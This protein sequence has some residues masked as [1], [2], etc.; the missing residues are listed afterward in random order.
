MFERFTDRARRVL[1]YAQ[2]EAGSLGHNFLGTEHILLGLVREGE[3][4]GAQ[5]LEALGQTLPEIQGQVLQVLQAFQE[6]G[7]AAGPG[8]RSPALARAL[9]DAARQA[10]DE[11]AVTTSHVIRSVLGVP[12]SQGAMA[13]TRLG[14]TAEAL[15]H[16]VAA[17]PLGQT[18]DS[19]PEARK[20]EIKLGDVTT[21]IADADLA[22]ALR[23]A[24]PEQIRAALQQLVASPVVE[25]SAGGEVQ[26]DDEPGEASSEPPQPEADEG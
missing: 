23:H 6:R 24:S 19:P 18:S 9:A 3:G 12:D 26:A 14:V 15:E 5:A 25:A 11:S 21:T 8:R 17:I 22:A 16:E 4:A 13:L 10:R 1:V 20:V 2:E 7:G